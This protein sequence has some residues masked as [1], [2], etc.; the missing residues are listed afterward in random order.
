MPNEDLLDKK[1]YYLVSIDKLKSTKDEEFQKDDLPTQKE[2]IDEYSSKAASEVLDQFNHDCDS[3]SQSTDCYSCAE[4]STYCALN[5][6][7]LQDNCDT[8]VYIPR[9]STDNNPSQA[10]AVQDD[11]KDNS[12]VKEQ[13]LVFPRHTKSG[14]VVYR[15]CDPDAESKD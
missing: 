5:N 4:E 3:S 2:F 13:K 6:I 7:S 14:A 15:L 9:R 11:S 12:R 10:S 1:H 8:L